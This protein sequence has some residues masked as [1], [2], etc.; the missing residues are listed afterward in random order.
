MNEVLGEQD[1]ATRL[2]FIGLWTLADREGRLEDRPK[3][4]KSAIFPYD[5][6][7]TDPML[8]RLKKD[9]FLV[10]Y[11]VDGEKYI[12]LINFVKHQDPHYKEKASEIPPVPG[13]ENLITAT[14]LTRSMKAAIIERDGGKCLACGAQEH[15]CVDHIVPASRGGS[16]DPANLQTLCFS[17]NARKGNKLDGEAVGMKR[18][19]HNDTSIRLRSNVRSN[20][21]QRNGHSPSDSLTPD[22]GFSDSLIPECGAGAPLTLPE[23]FAEIL[24]TRPELS[25]E[26]VYRKFCN[27][28]PEKQQTLTTWRQWVA[29]ERTA[30]KP[31]STADPD[32]RASI[33]ALGIARGMGKWSEMEPFEKYKARV[34]GIPA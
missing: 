32:S 25:A 13:T 14:G 3:R 5:S 24:K 28:K 12:Q 20:L 18:G 34:K 22:S 33:E 11:E 29:D 2:L 19:K 8:E 7:D 6:F 31:P 21:N 4:I 23:G 9:G 10:R 17:C 15:L 16:S 26:V 27:H 30:E 1:P